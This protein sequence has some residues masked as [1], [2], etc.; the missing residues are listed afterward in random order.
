MRVLQNSI[1]KTSLERIN[2]G[3][4]FAMLMIVSLTLLG[5]CDVETK[6]SPTYTKLTD[7]HSGDFAG[8]SLG[9]T[10]SEV[11]ANLKKEYREN[12]NTISYAIEDSRTDANFELRFKEDRL[13]EYNIVV[14]AHDKTGN[15]DLSSAA[16]FFA[17]L[18]SELKDKY[19]SPEVAEGEPPYMEYEYVK[20]GR[21]ANLILEENIVDVYFFNE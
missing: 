8:I 14:Y 9:Q 11:K 20:N 6:Y 5:A 17:E 19:G 10:K 7:N 16:S 13:M 4:F 1:S 3:N 18:N 2:W 15:N 12:K 21:R